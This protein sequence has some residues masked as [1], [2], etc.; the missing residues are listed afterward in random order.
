MAQS[1]WIAVDERTCEDLDEDGIPNDREIEHGLDPD[2][3]WD[4]DEDPDADGATNSEEYFEDQDPFC[5]WPYDHPNFCRDCGPCLA[6]MADCDT[7]SEC[8]GELVCGFNTGLAYGLPSYY[9]VCECPWPVDHPNY[10]RDCGPCSAG[11]A[12]CDSDS[13]CVD[14]TRCAHDVGTH[15]G[16]PSNYDVCECDL[17]PGHDDFCAVCGPCVWGDGDCD[18]DHECGENTYCAEDAGSSYG[19]PS[20]ADVCACDPYTSCASDPPVA[21]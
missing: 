6:G 3:L 14:G 20:R 7:D 15:Y 10:C 18:G 17:P 5:K 12:D 4:A 21:G 8:A 16:L 11:Y 19:L 9:D 2:D 1:N 13:E